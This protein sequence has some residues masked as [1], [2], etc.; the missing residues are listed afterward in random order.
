MSETSEP[1][2]RRS[3][4]S[5]RSSRSGAAAELP[6]ETALESPAEAAGEAATDGGGSS[7]SG[8]GR[9]RSS[10]SGEGSSR[11]R[12]SGL[13]GA[14]DAHRR[15]PIPHLLLPLGIAFLIGPVAVV[16]Q[17]QAMAPIA[18]IALAATV[19][20]F[21]LRR[22]HFPWPEG[23][24]TWAAVALMAWTMIASFW[25]PDP[26]RGFFTGVQI[27]AY[28]A[29]ALSAA[30][31]VAAAGEDERRRFALL[32]AIGIGLGLVTA[33]VDAATGNAL[34]ALV[35]GMETAPPQLVFGLKPAASTLA[36][37]LPLLLGAVMLPLW[38]RLLL[39][40]FGAA[41]LLLLPGEAAKLS[42]LAAIG[43]GAVAM[44]LPGDFRRAPAL[45]MGGLM[46]VAIVAAPAVLG[47]VLRAG[48]PADRMNPSAAHRMLVWYFVNQK[49]A[50]QPFLGWGTEASRSLPDGKHPPPARLLEHFFLDGPDVAP[51]IRSAE[52][53]PLHPHNGALQVWLEL[54]LMGALLAG[55]L[56]L[57]LGR[58]ASR[59]A[60]P[61][62]GAAMLAAYSVTALLSFGIWQEW[63]LGVQFMALC[64]VLALPSP[65][66]WR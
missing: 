34:R 32:A 58:A 4:R 60:W 27:S 33:G 42:V 8:S 41:V 62:V 57:F 51:W 28:V 38:L 59:I 5:S 11:R 30:G 63:W 54:G 7:G 22:Y 15:D 9:S 3:R 65:S 24:A 18:T 17:A 16:L 40:L 64:G 47:P 1:R 21:L 35:R 50:D 25:A 36:L 46:A 20:L 66:R 31:A 6:A 37:F 23:L 44:L 61:G 19:L 56:A 29:L 10:R 14:R 43:I 48:F 26:P 39:I 13:K 52:L 12:S 49:I 2:R 45:L 53:L 55:L